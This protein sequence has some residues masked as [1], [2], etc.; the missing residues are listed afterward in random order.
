MSIGDAG[1]FDR[2]S[3]L[4]RNFAV[5][6]LTAEVAGVFGREGIETI[7]LKGPVLARW[8]YPGEV[9]PYVDSDLMV[10][11]ENRAPAVGVLERLGFAEHLPW[12]PTPLSLDP[13]GTA[14]NRPG[15][16]MVDLH[17]QLPGLDGDPDAIWS[18]FVADAERQVIAGVELRVPD[19][20]TVLLHVV[21]H[22]AHHA[23]HGGGK[24]LEDLRRALARA[25]ES[26]WLRALELA[27][28]YCGVPAFAAGLLLLPEGGDLA[29]GL[30]L[31]E[32]RSLQHEIR[33]EN[34][35]IAEE[36]YILLCANA[37]VGLKLATA[38]SDLFP[39]PD[40][41]RWWSPLARRGK[42]GLAGAYVWRAMWVI[43][44][45]PRALHTLWRVRQAKGKM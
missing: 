44:Q 21:L 39:R 40:Y 30:N 28:A 31:G 25:E 19:R 26:E 15:E 33:R 6:A 35:V 18:R 24:P 27:R 2:Y 29:R 41:M 22:A 37:G 13:G 23:D 4:A 32:V 34:N 42:L 14:F 36:L 20:D 3:Q 8:L 43:G 16:G 1:R 45:A 5:D 17:C 9:R 7:V 10:A 11:R 38:I 12:M